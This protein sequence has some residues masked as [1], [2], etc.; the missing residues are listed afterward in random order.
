MQIFRRPQYILDENLEKQESSG[1]EIRTRMSDFAAH[2][3][4]LRRDALHARARI[5][6][7][8]NSTCGINITDALHARARIEIASCW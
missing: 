6:I 8:I 3:G 2:L 1:G 5:E 4:I 7:G